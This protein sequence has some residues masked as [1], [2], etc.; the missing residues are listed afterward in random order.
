MV[1]HGFNWRFQPK[2]LFSK[3]DFRYFRY[4]RYFSSYQYP[5]VI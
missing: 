5:L 2:M 3:G 1:L 4:F